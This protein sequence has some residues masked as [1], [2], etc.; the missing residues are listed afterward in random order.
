MRKRRL[1]SLPKN[2]LRNLP[3][4][5]TTVEEPVQDTAEE[6]SGSDSLEANAPATMSA[7]FH[8][9]VYDENGIRL[10][11]SKNFA[12]A[13]E[14]TVYYEVYL[15]GEKVKDGTMYDVPATAISVDFEG[16]GYDVSY[17]SSDN[18]VTVAAGLM[19][20]NHNDA[21]MTISIAKHVGNGSV[22]IGEYGTFRWVKGDAGDSA[23]LRD[24]TVQ[25]NGEEVYTQKI[26]TP[27]SLSGGVNKAFWFEP[28]LTKYNAN[29]EVSPATLDTVANRN[30]T[31]SLTTKCQC[32]RANCT[33]EGGNCGCQKDCD[34]EK[35]NHQEENTIYTEYG[36]IHYHPAEDVFGAINRKVSVELYVNGQKAYTTESPL[37]V[38]SSWLGGITFDA[39]ENNGYY[40]FSQG[41][42]LNSY[43]IVTEGAGSTWEPGE[44]TLT[45]IG[46]DENTV[47]TLKIYLWTFS[48]YVTLNVDRTDDLGSDMDPYAKVNGYTISFQA[49]NPKTGEKETYSYPATSFSAGQRQII[50]SGEEVTLTADCDLYY[51]VSKWTTSPN[52]YLDSDVSLVG[53]EGSG[54]DLE[55][56]TAQGNTVYLTVL[57]P[58]FTMVE[59]RMDSV[60]EVKAP[61]DEEMKDLL[62]S[63]AVKVSCSSKP[64]E[65]G[66]KDYALLD[67]S[68]TADEK[69]DGNS[70]V[71]YTYTIHVQPDKYVAEYTADM[72]GV[73]HKN[74][75]PASQD[76]TFEFVAGK[77]T[78][79]TQ[80]PVE[81]KVN[82]EEETPELPD[83]PD[84]EKL[85]KDAVLIKCTT[86][87]ATHLDTISKTYGAE[88]GGY[89]LGA[90][91]GNVYAG[92][93]VDVTVKSN[94]YL[95]KY[96]DETG[97]KHGLV[98]GEQSEKTITL[99]YVEGFGWK[100][101]S[102]I[103]V[104]F[105]VT[106]ENQAPIEDSYK[107]TVNPA[108]MTIYMGGDTESTSGVTI[109]DG[110][111]D[112][113]K[114][115]DGSLPEIGF[116]LQ[117]SDELNKELRKELGVDEK[118]VLDLSKYI[119]LTAVTED[120]HTPLT[121]SLTKYGDGTSVTNDGRFIYKIVPE[122][123]GATLNVS[124]K[125]A[126]GNYVGTDDFAVNEHNRLY[127]EYKMEIYGERVD[128]RTL[129]AIIEIPNN[130]M[131]QASVAGGADPATL[132]VRYVAGT[133]NEVVTHSYADIVTASKEDNPS[134]D[135]LENAYVIRS[136]SENASVN[137]F[138]VNNS[139][140]QVNAADVSLLF[141]NIV[142]S[143]STHY[144]DSLKTKAI[145]AAQASG[146]K[147]DDVKYQ[148]K[149]LDLVDATNGNAWVTTDE[150]VTVYWPF[151]EGTNKDTKFYVAHFE[152]LDRDESLDSM[153]NSLEGTTPSIMKNVRTDK[154]GI[155]FETNSFSPYV[156]LWDGAKETDPNPDEN[157]PDDNNN[158][159]NT[160]KVTNTTN[161]Q[162]QP[163]ATAAVVPQTGDTMP[164][165]LLGGLAAVAAAV[166]VTLLVIRKRKQN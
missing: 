135:A 80:T 90:I 163:Q 166:F 114:S 68:Y 96:N 65:H 24:L 130:D 103:P 123:K 87:D 144:L 133:Q 91:K 73:E 146:V 36:A 83:D 59:L 154:Y 141:D 142:A 124:F 1:K 139:N 22:Q 150:N 40:F 120:D 62:G 116:S 122:G 48:Q 55:Y 49:V 151:P 42:S 131:I 79:Q 162:T 107:I 143:E 95:A 77:W 75:Q 145:E 126:D 137:D 70:V 29:V 100:V 58:L 52:L 33:C 72:S 105:N 26:T 41:Q 11:F 45:I 127:E 128:A 136:N 43:D 64:N 13:I 44:G 117:L 31:V 102:D 39:A 5:K 129:Q 4:K 92:F 3:K 28:D 159:N 67:G 30:V 108:N 97:I 111:G 20:V 25:V 17:T 140:V 35:C 98:E 110:N 152:G 119:K 23:Y 7:S 147:F 2:L 56:M 113:I 61:T 18:G 16:D 63:S 9:T 15:E 8:E 134:Q 66:A 78:V 81:F 121:W 37:S 157:K 101:D 10:S 112:P 99:R 85:L 155:Y 156:L 38:R 76:I 27:E 148:A 12:S 86:G 164:V 82:C 54:K 165:G 71:N 84:I 46:G 94:V 138:M 69:L 51:E 57:E 21:H 104:I 125:D 6:Q 109:V 34:C 47:N 160:V 161:V 118:T 14:Y 74:V 153:Q 132:T 60:R 19:T 115:A 88:E 50:P 89:T 149:Y 32:G 53:E 158:N 106:C 93:T